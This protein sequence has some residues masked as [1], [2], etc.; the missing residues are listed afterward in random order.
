MYHRRPTFAQLNDY[1]NELVL[2]VRNS[3]ILLLKDLAQRDKTMSACNRHSESIMHM[4]CR[5]STLEVVRFMHEHGAALDQIDDY[6]RTPLHD[7]CWRAEPHFELIE[8]ILEQRVD[9]LRRAD[10]RGSTPL[11]YVPEEHWGV[12][13]TFIDTNK[14]K[15]W[16]ELSEPVASV[17]VNT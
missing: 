13:C 14:D 16:S 2:A 7:A 9:L 6:G 4:A 17:E 11:N 10:T 5:R 3:D 8:F 15:Y 12:W 1:D